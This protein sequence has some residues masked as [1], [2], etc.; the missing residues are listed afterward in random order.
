MLQKIK[1]KQ[2]RYD[3]KDLKIQGMQ[4]SGNQKEMKKLGGLKK[5]AYGA[6]DDF[7][8]ID[9]KGY[10]KKIYNFRNK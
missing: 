5:H 6:D 2:S 3:G 7:L 1:I 8:T 4:Q 9:P 10:L